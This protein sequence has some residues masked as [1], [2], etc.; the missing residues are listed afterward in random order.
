MA[1][2]Q[3]AD[4]PQAE[5]IR[6]SDNLVLEQEGTA[7]KLSGE[8]LAEFCKEKFSAEEIAAYLDAHPEATTTVQDGSISNQKLDTALQQEISGHGNDISVLE[9]RV[10]EIME[11][12]PGS[13]TGDAQL[14]DIKIGWDGKTYNEPGN[15]VRAQVETAESNT[16]V[17][18]GNTH[19][20]GWTLNKRISTSADV[21]N[22]GHMTNSDGT[23]CQVVD[24]TPGE[25][26]AFKALGN[27]ANYKT[28]CFC[29]ADGTKL[30]FAETNNSA[31]NGV[32]LIAPRGAAK[33]VMNAYFGGGAG[34]YAYR[35]SLL[36][37]K[38]ENRAKIEDRNIGA[39]GEILF[40]EYLPA[41]D[42]D[43]NTV[44]WPLIAGGVNFDTGA[45]TGVSTGSARTDYIR[46]DGSLAIS[47]DVSGYRVWGW[48]YSRNTSVSWA[49]HRGNDFTSGAD[50]GTLWPM[51][52]QTG[53][54]YVRI[55]ITRTDGMPMTT[56]LND[57]A[58]DWYIIQH[59][60]HIRKIPESTG[61]EAG[62]N[63]V[64]PRR[65]KSN[66]NVAASYDEET[67]ELTLT[68]V[69]AGSYRYVNLPG[70]WESLKNP[71]DPTHARPRI[72]VCLRVK[73][74]ST[75]GGTDVGVVALR[76]RGAWDTANGLSGGLPGT[77]SPGEY[78]AHYTTTG[79]ETGIRLYITSSA[80]RS[81]KV[82]VKDI[83]V[84]I[85]DA[86]MPYVP[87]GQTYIDHNARAV[88]EAARRMAL[89][90]GEQ[91]AVAGARQMAYAKWSPIKR[92]ISQFDNDSAGDIYFQAEQEVMGMPYSSARG[93]NKYLGAG[94]M[95]YTFLTAVRNPRSV[96]YTRHYTYN[97][98]C[99]Y[100][101]IVCSNLVGWGLKFGVNHTCAHLRKLPERID[102]G[103][104]E[105][106]PGDYIVNDHHTI[107]ITDV[108]RD[109]YGRI[110]SVEDIQSG[111]PNVYVGSHHWP[112]YKDDGI[113]G[114]YKPYR[115]PKVH[116]T[117]YD[118]L[119]YLW[120]FP[121][122]TVTPVVIP[123]I[124]SEY[125]D[126]AVVYPQARVDSADDTSRDEDIRI[127]VLDSTGY[128]QIM[129]KRDGSTVATISAI[130]DFWLKDALGGSI[131]AGLYEIEMTGSGKSSKT[132][133][134]V[135]DLS[136]VNYAESGG[137]VTVDFSS[138][139]DSRLTASA[140]YLSDERTDIPSVRF[141]RR[142]TEQELTDKTVE[143]DVIDDTPY[144]RLEFGVTVD[145]EYWGSATWFAHMPD[146]WRPIVDAYT[147]GTAQTAGWLS[148]TPG[149]AALTPKSGYYYLVQSAGDYLNKAYRWNGSAYVLL[150]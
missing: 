115:W 67:G 8:A 71:D 37:T 137:K 80:S 53:D 87:Y 134:Y 117:E 45:N 124:M 41:A 39:L 148:D 49:T 17:A 129:V 100:Y 7:K 121:D 135:A 16:A 149:G 118:S 112:K 136:G 110:V 107:M 65:I 35:N 96:L 18:T 5:H 116:A 123:D 142:V 84:A 140:T 106:H 46:I 73:V 69:T 138:A 55:N 1:D 51:L 6:T 128:T 63:L 31:R 34:Y 101:G 30:T 4:L 60:L 133:I 150:T 68:T 11:L 77:T 146:C 104:N 27:S 9:S 52:R 102:L 132:S 54:A 122:E 120:G 29:K 64:D 61:I 141:G 44:Y 139:T 98:A 48:F 93:A 126:K 59:N 75:D 86:A 28:W 24:V 81:V 57:P 23:A 147:V 62:V 111:T 21:V 15:A 145:G 47:M 119:S 90:T 33:L 127:N 40:E 2:K 113:A 10:D 114:G 143:M 76:F 91:N 79:Y 32:T 125:G 56:D 89:D 12:T 13:T 83:M 131:P 50:F 25:E 38:V 78:V 105:L 108:V 19:M 20:N 22:Y 94:V 97:N 3:I 130:A 43:G 42:E 36:S 95:P 14:A 103:W 82:I 88:A 74:T 144:P 85:S 66:A 92:L 109:G 72:K 99:L 26:I 70:V 58:S